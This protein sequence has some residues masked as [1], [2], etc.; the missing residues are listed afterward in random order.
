[1]NSGASITHSRL[2]KAHRKESEN[3]KARLHAQLSVEKSKDADN[4][5][6]IVLGEALANLGRDEEAIQCLKTFL[7]FSPESPPSRQVHD[8]I[9]FLEDR[10]TTDRT[11]Q[12]QPLPGIDP[13][14]VTSESPDSDELRI[15]IKTWQPPGIDDRKPTVAVGVSCPY[16]DVI[17]KA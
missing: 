11:R 1:M 9:A 8:L 13:H 4:T 15:S 5:A 10:T 12:V 2:A 17:H 3:E 6:Q 16:E 7:K 14:L